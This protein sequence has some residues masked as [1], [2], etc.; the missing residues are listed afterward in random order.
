MPIAGII[1]LLFFPAGFS[2][3]LQAIWGHELTHQLL[4]FAFALSCIEQAHMATVDLQQIR[5]VQQQVQDHRLTWFY[6]IT[7]S[8]IVIELLGYYGAIGWLGWGTLTVL[9][10]QIWFNLLAGIQL[11]PHNEK[12]IQSF[13][14][15]DRWPVLIADAV[16]LVLI[17]FWMAHIADLVVVSILCAMFLTYTIVKYALPAKETRS[18]QGTTSI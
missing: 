10:S 14:I 2:L 5:A 7:L 11:H 13:G 15:V 6:R 12:P 8:T 9:L 18:K 4:A 1:F 17:G 3:T 16:G